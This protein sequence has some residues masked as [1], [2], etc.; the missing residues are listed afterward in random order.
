MNMRHDITA[1][2]LITLFKGSKILIT[3]V[4]SQ[5]GEK[6][7]ITHFLPKPYSKV[8]LL[9]EAYILQDPMDMH[10]NSFD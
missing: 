6:K 8:R 3:D 1:I 2:N 9:E 5:T 7:K 10:S 4:W